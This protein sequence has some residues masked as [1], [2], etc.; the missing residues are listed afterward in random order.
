MPEIRLRDGESIEEAIRRFKRECEREGIL[1][2][3][4]KRQA[5]MPPSVKRKVKQAEARKKSRRRKYH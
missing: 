2:E 3:I 1:Q 4:R 5:Y